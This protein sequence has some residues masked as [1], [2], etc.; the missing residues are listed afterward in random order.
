MMPAGLMGSK[1][2][3]AAHQ[4]D[5][6]DH[7]RNDEQDVNESAHRVGAHQTQQ[8]Q[9]QKDDEDCPEHNGFLS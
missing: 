6:Q 8:P 7:Y 1:R 3:A 4:V 9:H 2:S 5:D